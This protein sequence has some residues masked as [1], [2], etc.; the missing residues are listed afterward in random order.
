[1]QVAGEGTV[2]YTAYLAE[3]WRSRGWKIKIFDRERNEEPHIT[4]IRGTAYWR[5]GLRSQRFLDREPDSREVP[6]ALVEFACE[7]I[8]L[9]SN[10]WNMLHP[11]NPVVSKEVLDE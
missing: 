9:L 10:A 4:I 8:L 11:H 1:M 7:N 3:P 5:W 2:A 6:R